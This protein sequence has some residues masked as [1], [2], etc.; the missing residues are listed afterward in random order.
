MAPPEDLQDLYREA[1]L[2]RHGL[3]LGSI[4]LTLSEL[5]MALIDEHG[6]ARLLSTFLERVAAANG[7]LHVSLDVD[8]LDAGIA[9]GVGT[10]VPGGVTC[11]FQGGGIATGL[12]PEHEH[13]LLRISQ[14]A[15]SNAVRHARPRVN[16]AYDLAR[17]TPTISRIPGSRTRGW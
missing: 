17:R 7:I 14:E 16:P 4:V 15:V 6:V 8:F 1:E 10:T 9:P 5:G 12:K 2:L 3:K 11:T 13:E